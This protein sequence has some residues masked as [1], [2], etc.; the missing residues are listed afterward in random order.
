[1]VLRKWIVNIWPI[2]AKVSPNGVEST[3]VYDASGLPDY[4]YLSSA[5]VPL[6]TTKE[7][8]E[9]T[10]APYYQLLECKH[11]VAAEHLVFHKP[12][13]SQTFLPAPVH[14]TVS[15]I[16]RDTLRFQML[17]DNHIPRF[18]IRRSMFRSV[19]AITGDDILDSFEA[20]AVAMYT[21]GIVEP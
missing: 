19:V 2:K 9:Y 5:L 7:T 16:I 12:M 1:L 18:D 13:L 11:N 8:Q 14:R 4:Q 3:L 15:T 20:I 21:D 6:K 10:N 17:S